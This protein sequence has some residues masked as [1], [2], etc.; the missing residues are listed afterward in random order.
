MTLRRVLA[1]SVDRFEFWTA[2]LTGMVCWLLVFLRLP[3]PLWLYVVGHELTHAIWA[4]AFGV[5]VKAMKISRRGG[6]VVL[7]RTHFLITLAPY[8]F[9]LYAV[10]WTAFFALGNA[11][12]NWRAWMAFYH[13]GLGA[14]YAFHATLTLHILRFRQ[15]DLEMEG[16][17]FSFVII[18]V[19]NVT[20]LLGALPLLTQG[21]PMITVLQ[22]WTQDTVRMFGIARGLV[23]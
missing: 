1:A 17:L 2:L 11:V 12:W 23:P 16:W 14:T 18:M 15:P 21:V 7:N 8:F 4:I 20:V 3:P 13:F 19:G 9:P 10:L 22:W 6:H 5:K